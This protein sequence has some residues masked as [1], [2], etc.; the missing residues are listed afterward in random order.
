M[1]L[2][3]CDDRLYTA[4]LMA[5]NTGLRWGEQM[6]LQWKD[7]DFRLRQITLRET[8]NHE[9]R[10]VPMNERLAEALAEHRKT[11]ARKGGRIITYV[12]VNPVTG[13]PYIDLRKRFGAVLRRA[14]IERHFTWHGLRH[15][16]A[17]QMVMSGVNLRTVG[18]I[19]GHK[20]YAMTLRYAH[21]APGFLQEASEMLSAHLTGADGHSM[22]TQGQNGP[23]NTESRPEDG[24]VR[25]A[26]TAS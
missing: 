3:A 20:S 10:H 5:V 12:F 9:T 11:Q 19:L 8:K 26:K 24:S 14:G 7:V 23:D 2:A 22:D 21:V 16:A 13:E 17:S 1:L 25:K 6:G 15:T 4:V 18:K